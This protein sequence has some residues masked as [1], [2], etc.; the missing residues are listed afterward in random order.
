MASTTFFV[1]IV[2]ARDLDIHVFIMP[3]LCM[4]LMD[5]LHKNDCCARSVSRVTNFM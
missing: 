1:V 5:V 3:I 4:F 2:F